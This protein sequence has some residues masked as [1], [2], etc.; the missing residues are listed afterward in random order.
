[1]T[2]VLFN[3]DI[4]RYPALRSL[5]WQW[6]VTVGRLPAGVRAGSLVTVEDCDA[7]VHPC[8]KVDPA[9]SHSGATPDG[10][11]AEGV[12]AAAAAPLLVIGAGPVSGTPWI[13][14]QDPGP[15]GARLKAALKSCQERARVLRGDTHSRHDQDQ[16]RD[17]LGHELRSP[18]TAIKTALTVL[19]A[20][21]FN[22]PGSARMLG[23]ARRNL[24]RLAETVEWS[25]ELMTLAETS[26][27]AEPGPVSLV[28]VADAIPGHLDVHLDEMHESCE[29]LTDPRLLG[30][31]AGQLERVLTYVCPES[32]PAFGLEID[33]RSGDCRLSATIQPDPKKGSDSRDSDI[34]GRDTRHDATGCHGVELEYLARMLISPHLLQV[35]GVRPRLLI[36]QGDPIGLSIGLARC[37]GTQVPVPD[38]SFTV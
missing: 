10:A 4:R 7:V 22:E 15:G 38:P 13:T 1:L 24:L 11:E 35:L 21:R 6:G 32:R 5:L 18:L 19:E 30:I 12:V 8:G 36:E 26:P 23:I 9:G 25:Q 17:F 27:V 33:S 14:I 37:V 16:F 31:L 34:A 3:G 20:E 2:H 28:A 29:V